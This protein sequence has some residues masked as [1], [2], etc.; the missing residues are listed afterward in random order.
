MRL[1]V[2]S[3]F[4]RIQGDVAIRAV[5][6]TDGGGDFFAGSDVREM[7]GGTIAETMARVE[8]LH[9]VIRA[10]VPVIAAVRGVCVGVGC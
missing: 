6:L 2:A 5:I 7:G 9:G 4:K 1:D 10:D 3:V 8:I